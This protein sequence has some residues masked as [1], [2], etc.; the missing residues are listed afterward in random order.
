MLWSIGE[1]SEFCYLSTQTLRFYHSE[2]LLVPA[3]VDE[4]TGYRS[5]RF[6]QVET[7]ML[8]TVLRG[9]GMSVQLVRR[10]L[11][12]S[13]T[14]RIV[15]HEHAEDL[16]RRRRAED[17]A[18]SDARELLDDWPEVRQQHAPAITV[19]SAIAPA[20]PLEHREG[21]RSRYSWEWAETA[22]DTTIRALA[23]VAA[24][25]QARI[26]GPPWR[27]AAIETPEQKQRNLTSEGPHWVVKLPV[28]V[29]GAD[30][31]DL[32][33]GVEVQEFGPRD[34]LSIV[35]PGR[36]SMAKYGTSLYR[37]AAHRLDYG[38]ID[39][40]RMRQVLHPNSVETAVAIVRL[41]GTE[42]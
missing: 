4:R 17:E 5:Y 29:D 1:F 34:E 3:E 15:L 32:P 18:I 21:D 37:V 8:I 7:A 13:D 6:D 24:S 11:D 41:D 25:R 2:G 40:G 31:S 19:L 26:A 30:L 28:A 22:T 14:M 36:S 16:L 38:Y 23:E 9:T 20:V 12:D 39:L 33:D 35:I 10:A 42:A 27:S